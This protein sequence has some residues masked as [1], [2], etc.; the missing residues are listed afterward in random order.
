M[1]VFTPETPYLVG[2]AVTAKPRLFMGRILP[3]SLFQQNFT[4]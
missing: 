2:S 4:C 1:K 3:I